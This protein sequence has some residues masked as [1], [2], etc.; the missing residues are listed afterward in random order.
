MEFI[1]IKIYVAVFLILNAKKTHFEALTLSER[2]KGFF[3][4][5]KNDFSADGRMHVKPT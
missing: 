3:R 2:K 4:H 5:V 1:Q